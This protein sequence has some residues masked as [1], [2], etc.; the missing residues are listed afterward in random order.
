[1]VFEVGQTYYIDYGGAEPIREYTITNVKPNE[2]E[3]KDSFGNISAS[4]LDTW[5]Q[6]IKIYGVDIKKGIPSVLATST[7]KTK[8]T[9]PKELDN[10]ALLFL[11][12]VFIANVKIE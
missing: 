5:E 2:V 9:S 11:F 8:S 7:S 1:M 12:I 10:L 4:T 6:L 3:Y